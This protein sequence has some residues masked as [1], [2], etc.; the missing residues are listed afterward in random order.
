MDHIK[1]VQKAQSFERRSWL[2][3]QRILKIVR[4]GIPLTIALFLFAVPFIWLGQLYFVG[5]DNSQLY[6][7]MPREMMNDYL[8]NIVSDNSL[9]TLG[10]LGQQSYQ[11]PFFGLLYFLKSI[12]PAATNIQALSFGVNLAFSFLGF[13]WLLSLWIN[14]D[15]VSDRLVR[16]VGGIAF[17]SSLFIVSTMWKHALYALYLTSIFPV[18]LYLFLRGVRQQNIR[19]LVAAALLT[20]LF[21]IVLMAVPW[22]VGTVLIILPLLIWH[23]IKYRSTFRYTAYFALI[24]ILLNIFWLDT[25]VYS[26]LTPDNF[27]SSLS[28]P[29]SNDNTILSVTAENNI[30][31]PLL[32]D[33]MPRWVVAIEK[34]WLGSLPTTTLFSVLI[35]VAGICSRKS[36][37]LFGIY[38]VSLLCW[39]LGIYFYTVRVGDWGID[40]FLMLNRSIPGFTIF[41]NNFDK[42]SIGIAFS[43][44]F[45]VAIS[46]RILIAQQ[47][48]QNNSMVRRLFLGALFV[49]VILQAFPFF[50]NS[51]YDKPLWTTKST[52]TTISR[53]NEDFNALTAYLK[54]ETGDTKYLWLP[55]NN[56]GYIQISDA[57]LPN[58]YY[59]G[60]SPLRFL[61]NKS[62]Y[63]GRFSFGSESLGNEL[64]KNI[65]DNNH[66]EI[67]ALIRNMNIGYVILNKDLS[68][69]IINSY[70]YT[71]EHPKDLYYAQL[72]NLKPYI[73]GAHVRDFGSRY[74]IYKIRPEISLSKIYLIG[75]SA[76]IVK[77]HKASSSEYSLTL[78]DLDGF[79]QLTFLEP[80]HSQWTL[81]T[82]NG[83][84]LT[85]S[86]AQH[87]R[88][89]GY[90]NAWQLDSKKLVTTLPQS[91]FSRS[92]NGSLSLDLQ[93]E[94]APARWLQYG[95]LVSGIA[96]TICLVYLVT[97]LI[98]KQ[99]STRKR[100]GP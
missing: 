17:C 6:Y 37:H 4:Y 58:H 98:P 14:G 84:K 64:F 99:R 43:F 80:F 23:Q 76:P 89:H 12:L 92:S 1:T 52:Y 40:F 31:Y 35:I 11:A 78:Y 30:A 45:L 60:T 24:L 71:V 25:M 85:S 53:F 97:G 93:L 48:F 72:D 7:L 47:F 77:W 32:G 41:R 44:A 19:Y 15:N 62:D 50:R 90:A 81:T 69:D 33:S 2:P 38:Y 100:V 46:I 56:A 36:S 63:T 3:N 20:T 42:F 66:N 73:L 8:F 86:L 88:I 51:L 95:F 13:Y 87:T 79:F 67:I 28:S 18:V 39:I 49:I 29:E 54:Q 16:A 21:S 57:K 27:Y 55:L 59:S 22:L 34:T 83:Q 94:F 82:R 10:V 9:G 61:A 68:S 75:S 91:E 65:I 70:L 26:L 5:G 96:L 74:S